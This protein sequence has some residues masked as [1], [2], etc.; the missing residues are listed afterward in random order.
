MTRSP[1]RVL[2]VAT[3]A[4]TAVT[5]HAAPQLPANATGLEGMPHARVET[6]ADRTTREQLSAAEASRQQLRIRIDNGRLFWTSRL[7]QPLSWTTAGEFTYLLSAEPGHYVRFRRIND[8]LTYVE[9]L[10]TPLGSVTYWGELR[11]VLRK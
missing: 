9:H 10:E 5:V 7:D 6:S 3:L 2:L 11:I 1:L 4:C 8:R